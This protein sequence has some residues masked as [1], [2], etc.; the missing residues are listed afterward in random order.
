LKQILDN[1]KKK[2]VDIITKMQKS[3]SH[4]IEVE[5]N[6]RME[7]FYNEKEENMKFMALEL[8]QQKEDEVRIIKEEMERIIHELKL[9]NKN[10]NEDI[11]Q[12]KID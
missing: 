1:E 5:V 3:K 10:M 9:D 4:E 11:K 8:K 12:M 2:Y 7:M 6:N